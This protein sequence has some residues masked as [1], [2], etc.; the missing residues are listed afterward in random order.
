MSDRI[1][2]FIQEGHLIRECAFGNLQLDT[3][4]ISTMKRR[5]VTIPLVSSFIAKCH[6]GQHRGF[7]VLVGCRELHIA[8][9]GV[10]L[11]IT[12]LG[13]DIRTDPHTVGARHQHNVVVVIILHTTCGDI[14]VVILD[15]IQGILRNA[16][17]IVGLRVDLHHVAVVVCQGEDEAGIVVT[18][19]GDAL[20]GKMVRERLRR[21]LAVPEQC[22]AQ[23]QKKRGVELPAHTIKI[24]TCK[25]YFPPQK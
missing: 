25:Y 8:Y 17:R 3:T 24:T 2:L 14:L 23:C 5:T 1:L 12:I 21:N 16:H 10:H 19:S 6:I 4:H 11:R 18:L 15:I 7:H 22:E 9:R 13:G 20:H